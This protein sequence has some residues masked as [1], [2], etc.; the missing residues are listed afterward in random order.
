MTRHPRQSFFFLA[1]RR[2]PGWRFFLFR[3]E[4]SKSGQNGGENGPY[5]KVRRGD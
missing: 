1:G 2:L 4:M 5:N 3:E